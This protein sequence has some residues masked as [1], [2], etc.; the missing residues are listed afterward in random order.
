MN[1][2]GIFSDLRTKEDIWA[3]FEPYRNNDVDLL[4]W[5]TFKGENCTYRSRIGRTLTDS[6]NPFDRFAA[7]ERWAVTIKTLE[8]QGIDFMT[9][10]VKAAHT[11]GL[12]IFPS[13]RLQGPKAVPL[14]MEK[15]SFAARIS[16]AA[17]SPIS[18]W[19][20]LKLDS[21][22]FHSSVK[23]WNTGLIA[24]TLFSAAPSPSCCMRNRSFRDSVRNTGRMCGNAPTMIRGSG[25]C[26]PSLSLSSPVNS[27]RLSM[28]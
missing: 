21:C 26:C 4:L 16:T 23:H 24:C 22:E 20:S 27:K 25:A 19:L 3:Q 6:D 18:V 9:E 7:H 11:L 14:E 1:D 10:V 28:P 2:G 8:E 13:L 5:T 15:G 12:R 17:G